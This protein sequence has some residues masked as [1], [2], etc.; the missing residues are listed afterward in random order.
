[1]KKPALDSQR[2]FTLCKRLLDQ[3]M[4]VPGFPVPLCKVYSVND[5]T[6]EERRLHGIT[7]DTDGDTDAAP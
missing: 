3:N 7:S 2:P 4:L 5:L 6:A 1:M